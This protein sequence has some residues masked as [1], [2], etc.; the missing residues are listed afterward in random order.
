MNVRLLLAMAAGLV[1]GSVGAV[2]FQD[3][4]P[5]PPGTAEAK[6]DALKGELSRAKT[7]I[8]RLEAQVPKT[9][10]STTDKAR[11]G[12]AEILDD[13]KRGRPVDANAVFNHTKPVLRDLSPVFN[14]MRRREQLREF[15]RISSHMAEAYQLNEAQRNALKN[16]LGER[17]TQDAERFNA[18]AFADNTTLEDLAKLQRYQRP[19]QALDEFMDRTLTGDTLQRYDGDRLRERA[20]NVENL[21]NNRVN[22]LNSVVQLDSSQQDRV[23]SIMARSSPDF[24]ARMNLDGIGPTTTTI[25]P[26]QDREQAIL[27]VLRPD[28]RQRYEAYRQTQREEAEKEANESGFRLPAHWDLFEMD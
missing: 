12:V 5:P 19:N 13:I 15:D 23:F 7:M 3:S 26:G 1:I 4:L 10:P 9:E 28:Q 11:S 16:W 27:N 8:A 24:D 25:S 18:V 14:L 2:L 22:R 21:A 20:Q 6:A 17:A